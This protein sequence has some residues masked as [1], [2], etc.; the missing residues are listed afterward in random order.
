MCSNIPSCQAG[1]L[2]QPSSDPG[3]VPLPCGSLRIAML[4]HLIIRSFD[5][6]AN[7][8]VLPYERSTVGSSVIDSNVLKQDLSHGSLPS[9][10]HHWDMSFRHHMM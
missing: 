5:K 8:A 6:L 2:T 7:T 9:H 10:K 4:S 3:Y 1:L